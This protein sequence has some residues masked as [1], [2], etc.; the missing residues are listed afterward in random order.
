MKR[1]ARIVAFLVGFPALPSLLAGN[2]LAVDLVFKDKHFE[3]LKTK[4]DF[5][6][7]TRAEGAEEHRQMGAISISHARIL[8]WLDGIMNEEF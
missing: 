1:I 6:L 2:A 7:F 8:D 5:P 4:K 3:A